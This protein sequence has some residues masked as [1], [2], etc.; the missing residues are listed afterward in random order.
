MTVDKNILSDSLI[1]CTFGV[2]FVM[3]H[4]ILLSTQATLFSK[5]IFL[6]FYALMFLF[7]MYSHFYEKISK[8]LIIF[9]VFLF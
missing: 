3:Q 7:Y 4:N 1:I 5:L 2:V 6:D 9:K 8:G